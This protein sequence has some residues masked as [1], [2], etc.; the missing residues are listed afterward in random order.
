[1]TWVLLACAIGLEVLGTLCLKVSD[2]M[3]RLRWVAGTVV[4][5]VLAFA[6]IGAVL[7]RGVAVGVVYGI[8]VACGVALTAV[9][10]RLL[11]RDPLTAKMVFGIA[12]IVVGVVAVELGANT[13]V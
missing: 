2:G 8:W 1:M 7:A 6:L 5:Y 13:P 3:A 11:F 9:L 4:C 12:L 10:G